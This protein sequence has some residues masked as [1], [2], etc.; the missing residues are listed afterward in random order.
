MGFHYSSKNQQPGT[1]YEV[2]W[3][4]GGTVPLHVSI[5]LC[6]NFEN[7]EKKSFVC[8]RP[9]CQLKQSHISFGNT[10]WEFIMTVSAYRTSVGIHYDL[11]SNSHF[12]KQNILDQ[13][14]EQRFFFNGQKPYLFWARIFL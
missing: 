9:T 5:M 10:W 6:S 7:L 4:A 1:G 2:N 3:S 14:T 11:L 8:V 13:Y 12:A